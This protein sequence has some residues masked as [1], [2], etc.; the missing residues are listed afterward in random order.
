[1]DAG[2]FEAPFTVGEF[3]K[4]TFF[5]EGAQVAHHGGLAGVELATDLARGRWDAVRALVGFNEVENLV[6]AFGEHGTFN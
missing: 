4:L 2:G 1:M 3:L 6:L 5:S